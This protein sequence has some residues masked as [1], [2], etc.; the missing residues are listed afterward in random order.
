MDGPFLTFFR[1]CY[2][3]IFCLVFQKEVVSQDVP[4]YRFVPPEDVFSPDNPENK[5]FCVSEPCN[6]P[7]GLFNMSACQFDSPTLISWPHFFQV[8]LED[9]RC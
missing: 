4:G 6:V 8:S 7:K 3:F 5:C 9:Y 2:L 1:I